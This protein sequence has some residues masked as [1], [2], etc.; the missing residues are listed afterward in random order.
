[1]EKGNLWSNNVNSTKFI[2]SKF[3]SESLERAKNVSYSTF[4]KSLLDMF[5]PP[6]QTYN[7]RRPGHLFIVRGAIF[8]MRQIYSSNTVTYK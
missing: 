4:M 2:Y 8:F 1:M 6:R 7:V 5:N 3:Y